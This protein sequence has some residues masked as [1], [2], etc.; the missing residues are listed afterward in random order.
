METIKDLDSSAHSELRSLRQDFALNLS[1]KRRICNTVGG[2]IIESSTCCCAVLAARLAARWRAP[3]YDKLRA[4]EPGLGLARS[5]TVIAT[6]AAQR[7]KSQAS[8]AQNPAERTRIASCSSKSLTMQRDARRT[9][10]L[11]TSNASTW[12][13]RVACLATAGGNH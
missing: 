12:L 13:F 7:A 10:S 8:A 11:P 2:R 6:A 4:L 9:A 5:P 1:A 3:A